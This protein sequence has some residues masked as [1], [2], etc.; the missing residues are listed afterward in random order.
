MHNGDVMDWVVSIIMHPEDVIGV[1]TKNGKFF[2][3][4]GQN[5]NDVRLN[6]DKVHEAM[7]AVMKIPAHR[8]GFWVWKISH[9]WTQ[10]RGERITKGE[11]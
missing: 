10:M 11:D 6:A 1:L 8:E 9:G 7:I 3:I 4:C 2:G 5:E